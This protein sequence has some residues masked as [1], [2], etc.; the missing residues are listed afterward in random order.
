LIHWS[1]HRYITGFH[2]SDVVNSIFGDL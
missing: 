1:K 2:I